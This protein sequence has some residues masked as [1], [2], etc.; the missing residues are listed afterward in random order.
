MSGISKEYVA[1]LTILDAPKD[2]FGKWQ[3][4]VP[5]IPGCSS[6]GV[7]REDVLVTVCEAITSHT[8]I[9]P[10]DCDW[11][12]L[13]DHT[14]VDL[15]PYKNNELVDVMC[16]V[17]ID[18]DIV[19]DPENDALM[20]KITHNIPRVAVGAII[21]NRDGDVLMCRRPHGPENY[22]GKLHT[23]GGKVDLG[24]TL[25]SAIVREVFE[26]CNIDI[27]AQAWKVDMIG[28]IEELEPECNYVVDGTKQMYHWVSAIWVFWLK[29]STFKNMEPHKHHDM[30]WVDV[31]KLDPLDIAP[32]AYHSFVLAG[33]LGPREEW[34]NGIE[35]RVILN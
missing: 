18:E 15:R 21:V 34:L 28:M 30:Q 7:S 12:L 3:A 31:T 33:L 29:D 17:W 2:Q 5:H 27:K 20:R 11:Y 19:V 13:D 8:K 26:E 25:H 6:T 35:D 1:V 14:T 24:E 32:S 10:I 4:I 23:F 22:V 16:D 9:K